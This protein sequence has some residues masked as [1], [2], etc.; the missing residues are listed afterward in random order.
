L[1]RLNLKKIIALLDNPGS[2]IKAIMEFNSNSH[3]PMKIKAHDWLEMFTKIPNLEKLELNISRLKITDWHECEIFQGLQNL[4]SLTLN[5][6]NCDIKEFFDYIQPNSLQKLEI[7]SELADFEEFMNR[8]LSVKDLAITGGNFTQMFA[9]HRI[10]SF[11]LIVCLDWKDS[12][13]G[14]S[15]YK[16]VPNDKLLSLIK[17]HPELKIFRAV[18]IYEDRDGIYPCSMSEDVIIA[19]CNLPY[20]EKLVIVG[21]LGFT[22]FDHNVLARCTAKE[23]EIKECRLT[24]KLIE[25]ILKMKNI[26]KLS[27]ERLILK[28]DQKCQTLRYLKVETYDWCDLNKILNCF[29]GL[30]NLESIRFEHSILRWTLSRVFIQGFNDFY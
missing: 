1:Q 10:E 25:E 3:T 27:V 19:L 20:L 4:R 26:Q 9:D 17:C 30:E 22:S 7:K 21:E 16:Y 2:L 28:P 23:V 24:D 11:T 6:Q 15:G 5:L 18:D 13:F 29:E 8:Q 12:Y 14:N